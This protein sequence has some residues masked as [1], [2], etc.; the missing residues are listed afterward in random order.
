M[1][2]LMP[3]AGVART[4]E[5][6][7]V[8]MEQLRLEPPA[9]LLLL[10]EHVAVTPP[11][12]FDRFREFRVLREP[13]EP[14]H[15]RGAVVA[16]ERVGT[17][18]CA[19][20]DLHELREPRGGVRLRVPGPGEEDREARDCRIRDVPGQLPFLLLAHAPE[21]RAPAHPVR[22]GAAAVRTSP[23]GRPLTG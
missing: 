4:V 1:V 20:V 9:V 23:S 3:A 8:R 10:V 17:A 7:I 12:G 22:A 15:E 14:A 11:H 13:R 19:A 16:A 2:A 6:Q 18:A 21:A 5:H